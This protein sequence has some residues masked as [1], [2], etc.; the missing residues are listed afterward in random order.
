MDNV[1]LISGIGDESIKLDELK[2]TKI[3][4]KYLNEW[5]QLNEKYKLFSDISNSNFEIPELKYLGK[6]ADDIK[7]SGLNIYDL[8]GY[9]E[10]RIEEVGIKNLD[11][12]N[13]GKIKNILSTSIG[14]G[15][16]H[17]VLSL[18]LSAKFDKIYFKNS[19]LSEPEPASL[20]Y[21]EIT[22]WNEFAFKNIEVQDYKLQEEFNEF[23]L[24]NFRI[25]NFVLDNNFT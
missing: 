17:E 14:R 5:F 3:N 16:E 8:M 22:N 24:E 18:I 12:E 1:I 23:H 7:F 20:K 11:F 10:L 4:K 6:I 13:F 21:F 15:E 2:I 9:A 25:S 19:K